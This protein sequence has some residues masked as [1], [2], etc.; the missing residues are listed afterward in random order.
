M[1]EGFRIRLILFLFELRFSIVF[2]FCKFCFSTFG[3]KHLFLFYVFGRGETRR[4]E[5][6]Q[7]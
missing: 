5:E 3:S 6:K 7:I 2:I 4:K 1:L